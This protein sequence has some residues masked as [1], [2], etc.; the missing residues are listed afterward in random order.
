MED[1]TVRDY[2]N[3]ICSLLHLRSFLQPQS[4]PGQHC[5]SD[6]NQ[7]YRFNF[8]PD[9]DFSILAIIGNFSLN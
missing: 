7:R 9:F 6:F 5:D 3:D 4:W 1:Y 2:A 8:Q